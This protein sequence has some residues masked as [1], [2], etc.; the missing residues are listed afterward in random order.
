ML[1][2]WAKCWDYHQECGQ[3]EDED[4][5]PAD[6]LQWMQGQLDAV[7]PAAS[8][9]VREIFVLKGAQG[10]LSAGRRCRWWW[11]LSPTTLLLYE[12][13]IV[14]FGSR[15][16]RFSGEE[17]DEGRGTLLLLLF[18][19]VC[20]NV[21]IIFTSLF[22]Y[23]AT[24]SSALHSSEVEDSPWNFYFGLSLVLVKALLFRH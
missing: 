17:Q 21:I 23:T 1:E 19:G 24:Y 2:W 11:W 9:Q 5:Q 7:N 3:C 20:S 4:C 18:V 14:V 22:H 8:S 12:H 6:D 15:F 13:D 10:E 16:R